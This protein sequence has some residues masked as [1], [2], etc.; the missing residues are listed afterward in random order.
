MRHCDRSRCAGSA[1]VGGGTG[2]I[3]RVG[4]RQRIRPRSQLPGGDVDRCAAAGKRRRRGGVA[5][6]GQD[7]GTGGR[8]IAG[9]A[10]DGHCH[11]QRLRCRDARRARRHHH[12]RCGFVHSEADGSNRRDIVGRVGRRESR[13]ERIHSS[14]EYCSLGHSLGGAA[15]YGCGIGKCPRKIAV[16]LVR[17]RVEY[18]TT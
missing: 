8:G 16:I 10:A 15:I 14:P 3:R 6:A 2:G 11:R 17:G 13:R 1:V 9:P 12:C 4:G 5:A 7:Y 18:P